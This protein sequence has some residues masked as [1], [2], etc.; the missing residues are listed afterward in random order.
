[1]DDI[2]WDLLSSYAGLLSL[3][4][5]SIYAG[6]HGSLPHQRKAESKLGQVVETSEEDE[7]ENM[8]RLSSD[9][10]WLF[11]VIGSAA[12][13]GLY[14]VVKYFG[15]DWINWF[16]GWYFSIVGI[17]SIWKSSV[18]LFRWMVGDAYWRTFHHFN[19]VIQK[20]KRAILSLSWRTPTLFLLPFAFVPPVLYSTGTGSRKSILITDI[21]GLSF[22]HNALS[23]L[24]IDSFKTGSILLGGLFLYDVWWVFGT[25]VMVKVATSLDAPIKLLW[26]KSLSLAD[27]R[28]YTMLG[29]GDIVIPGMFVALALRYD[30]HCYMSACRA[31]SQQSIKFLKP[32]FHAG[33]VAYVLGLVTTMTMMHVFHAAQPALLYLSPSCTLSFAVTASLR[34]ELKEVW[35]WNDGPE[36]E[37]KEVA[38]PDAEKDAK[39]EIAMGPV[40]ANGEKGDPHPNYQEACLS[41]T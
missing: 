10:A 3:A 41:K 40:A 2:D 24:K 17:G 39:A 12:L 20:N 16:L 13:L 5:L 32:Y 21:L 34:G 18:S 8:E 25:E 33:L 36:E 31:S 4:T 6:S 9:E 22:A 15:T 7:E 30:Y 14:M 23:L 26:P 38:R 27:E 37:A 19:F 35:N 1:M 11:P 29:L 28:G